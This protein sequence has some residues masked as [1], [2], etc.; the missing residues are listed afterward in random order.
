MCSRAINREAEFERAPL[1]AAP[2]VADQLCLILIFL[3]K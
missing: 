3:V 2:A 1:T